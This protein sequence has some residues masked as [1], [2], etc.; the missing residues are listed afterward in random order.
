MSLSPFDPT[1]LH[2]NEAQ[3]DFILEMYSIDN[4]T[5]LNFTRPGKAPA[6]LEK[7]TAQA[8]WA[9]V[10]TGKAYQEYMS[11][12][13]PNSDVMTRLRQLSGGFNSQSVVPMGKPQ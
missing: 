13:L 1:I 4:P 10:L 5:K 2:H 3:L 7:V 11:P 8:E 12:H 9:N 6:G